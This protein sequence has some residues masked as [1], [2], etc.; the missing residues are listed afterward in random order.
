M[1]KIV[2][3]GLIHSH[4]KNFR[5]LFILPDNL[6]ASERMPSWT[7]RNADMEEIVNL[8]IGNVDGFITSDNIEC[9]EYENINTDIATG[10]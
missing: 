6:S 8:H 1:Q 4:V 9:T 3:P 5:T 10:S 7:A 2:S